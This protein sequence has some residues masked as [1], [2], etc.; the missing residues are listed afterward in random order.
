MTLR[1]R[2]IA[3]NPAETRDYTTTYWED[4]HEQLMVTHLVMKLPALMKPESL[5]QHSQS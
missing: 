3:D 4:F 5:W 2:L 1:E